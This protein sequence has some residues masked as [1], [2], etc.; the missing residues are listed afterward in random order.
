MARRGIT[1]SQIETFRAVMLAGSMT[2]AARDLHTS[3]PNVSRLIAQL[4][5][6]TGLQLFERGPGRL[7]PTDDGTVF[8]HEV[9]RAFVGLQSLATAAESIR[10]FGSGRLRIAVM[11]NLATGFL[12]RVVK[13]F[14]DQHPQVSLSIHTA[15]SPMVAQWTASQFCDIGIVMS[16]RRVEGTRVEPLYE[17]DGVCALPPGHRLASR[18]TIRPADLAGEPFISFAEEAVTRSKVDKVFADAK[19]QRA[20]TMETPHG[21]IICS[22]V[23]LGLGVSIVNPLV[24]RD[25][26]HAGIVVRPFRPSVPY[27]AVLLFPKHRPRSAIA[28]RFAE[29]MREQLAQELAG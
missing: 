19:V 13:R 3:Q 20:I 9:Q 17:I 14:K 5:R 4:E 28:A 2:A 18:K 12:P 16:G 24:A 23:A 8:L 7:V 15:S 26:L 27:S 10:H 21:S 6:A 22:L 1:S 25:V 11:A 29:A